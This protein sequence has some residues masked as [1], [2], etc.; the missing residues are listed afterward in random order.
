MLLLQHCS[1][2]GLLDNHTCLWDAVRNSVL[3]LPEPGKALQAAHLT[4]S[5]LQCCVYASAMTQLLQCTQHLL[6][7]VSLSLFI[8]SRN[9]F[10]LM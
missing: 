9:A 4:V 1:G 7:P 2:A 8:E 5:Q 10:K 3:A 6:Y